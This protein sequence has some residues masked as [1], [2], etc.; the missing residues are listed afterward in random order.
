MLGCNNQKCRA[1]KQLPP[2]SVRIILRCKE[3]IQSWK[4]YWCRSPGSKDCTKF[5]EQPSTVLA[6]KLNTPGHLLWKNNNPGNMGYSS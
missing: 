2:S 5:P 6:C 4:Q 3:C 1:S